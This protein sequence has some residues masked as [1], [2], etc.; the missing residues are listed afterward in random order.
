VANNIST[1]SSE[2]SI[3]WKRELKFKS[4]TKVQLIGEIAHHNM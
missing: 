3:L 1:L 2:F 4:E